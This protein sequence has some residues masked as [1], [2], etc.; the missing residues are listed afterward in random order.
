M[1]VNT[2]ESNIQR[3]S[4]W[5]YIFHPGNLVRHFLGP[6]LSVVPLTALPKDS[7]HMQLPTQ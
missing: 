3:H 5:S 1:P 7:C 6:P 4:H 2:A